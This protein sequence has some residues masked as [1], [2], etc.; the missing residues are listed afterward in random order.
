MLK[1]NPKLNPDR[2][3]C[4]PMLAGSVETTIFFKVTP[5]GDVI[6]LDQ[7]YDN[8]ISCQTHPFQPV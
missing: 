3:G 7:L 5:D 6:M 8:F 4:A 1:L 2:E